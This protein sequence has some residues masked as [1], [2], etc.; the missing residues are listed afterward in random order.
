MI[1]MEVSIPYRYSINAVMQFYQ[2]LQVLCFNSLQVFYKPCRPEENEILFPGF[3]SLQVFYKLLYCL[4]VI[5]TKISFNSLQ[6][7]YKLSNITKRIIQSR[8]FNSLQVF[9][10]P[11]I[12][13]VDKRANIVVSIP[14]RYSINWYIKLRKKQQ[15]LVSIPYRYSINPVPWFT[16]CIIH[17]G[18]NSLQVFYKL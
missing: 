11:K 3:N 9:Y 12:K 14:Y 15:K 18:F 1:Y 7:F 17:Y 6:V 13:Y 10:K 2:W 16:V 5:N 8:C 4:L